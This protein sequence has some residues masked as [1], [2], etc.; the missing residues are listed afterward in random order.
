M[1][2]I[3]VLGAALLIGV[4]FQM[5]TGYALKLRPREPGEMLDREKHPGEFWYT[6]ALEAALG[7]WCVY[8]SIR[9]GIF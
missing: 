3:F 6:V 5:V 9:S 2:F 1:T 8:L 4:V 7:L